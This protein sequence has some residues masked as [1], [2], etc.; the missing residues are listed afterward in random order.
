MYNV[1]QLTTRPRYCASTLQ[2]RN[3]KKYAGQASLPTINFYCRQL[4]LYKDIDF[5]LQHTV[6]C[7]K[8]TNCCLHFCTSGTASAQIQWAH[9]GPT[10]PQRVV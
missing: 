9:L 1:V 10:R 5:K 4:V 7:N 8:S 6:A 2:N 3:V